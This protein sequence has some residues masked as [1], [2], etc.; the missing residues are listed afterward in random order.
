MYEMAFVEGVTKPGAEGRLR[1]APNTDF[2]AW[3]VQEAL[4]I[5]EPDRTLLTYVYRGF[6]WMMDAREQLQQ[7]IIR[8]VIAP[9]PSIVPGPSD[10]SIIAEVIGRVHARLSEG[11]AFGSRHSRNTGR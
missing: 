3:L 7:A 10:H 8:P 5:D 6:G 9:D 2:G 1:V 4:G 11:N